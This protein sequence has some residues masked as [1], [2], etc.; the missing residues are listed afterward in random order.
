MKQWLSY[1][2]V[3]LIVMQSI[4]AIA[5]TSQAHQPENAQ[6]P[7]EVTQPEL[8]E[9]STQ[10]S[11]DG[12]DCP[13]YCYCYCHLYLS[14]LPTLSLN[15]LPPLKSLVPNDYSNTILGGLLSSVFRPPKV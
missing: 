8:F 9:N 10:F 4:T 15:A 12:L 2:L 7:I 6:T 11:N 1:W 3:L 14:D 13:R 5:D